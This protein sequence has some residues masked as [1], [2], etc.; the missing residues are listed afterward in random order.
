M[1]LLFYSRFDDPIAW[2]EHLRAADPTLE[3]RVWPEVGDPV[4]IDAALVW[5]PPEGELR[6]FPNLKL[7]IKGI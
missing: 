4:D 6:K 1:A 2:S 3:V 5:K 7:I